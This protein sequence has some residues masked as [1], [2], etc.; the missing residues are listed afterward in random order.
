MLPTVPLVAQNMLVKSF[1][2]DNKTENGLNSSSFHHWAFGKLMATCHFGWITPA[3][4]PWL[5]VVCDS[6]TCDKVKAV[7]LIP[8][9]HCNASKRN[10]EVPQS[11]RWEKLTS[12]ICL[13]RAVF[14]WICFKW[15]DWERKN[16]RLLWSF[17]GKSE[18]W[19]TCKSS[20]SLCE[21]QI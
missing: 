6:E 19:V 4:L 2:D 16:W 7:K 14:V 1:K 9:S 20:Y 10:G 8:V 11:E 18:A 17:Q 5:K 12:S 15:T 13:W 3:I 21:N